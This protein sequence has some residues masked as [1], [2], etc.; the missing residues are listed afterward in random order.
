M[1]IS[2]QAARS[3]TQAALKAATLKDVSVRVT[4]SARGYLRFSQNQA[5]ASG[6]A[7][8]L[9]V[10]VSASVDGRSASVRGSGGDREALARL[11]AQ[12]EELARIAPVDPELMPPL[13]PQTY[14]QVDARDR[15]SAAIGA[16]ARAE[17]AGKMLRV[18][19]KARLDAAGMI[20]S[21][22]VAVA[23]ANT[24]GLFAY[25]A[26][27]EV[28][29]SM[30]CRTRDGTG[31]GWASAASHRIADL[32][33]TALATRAAD[34]ATLSQNPE[35]LTPGRVTVVLEPAAV[36]DLLA[37]LGFALDRRS[38]DEG[39]SAFSRAG[40]GTRIGEAIGQ[41]SITLR[42]N[43]AEPLCPS[44][45]FAGDGQPHPATT[46]IDGGVLKALACSRYWAKR[47][48]LSPLPRPASFL[49]SGGS[50][51]VDE[52]VQ[53]VDR[54]V[55]VTRFWYNRML[56]PQTILATGLTRD[57]TFLIEQGK[58]VR[59][60]KNMRYNESPLTLLKNVLALGRP[61]RVGGGRQTVVVPPMVVADFNFSSLSDAV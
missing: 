20:E 57:G 39:R 6:E 26:S 21:A 53:G 30:T 55:L 50:A 37:F 29:A 23:L 18:A 13:G 47:E 58:V 9:E 25:H 43:P 60:I 19:N 31:S 33:P 51:S 11:V 7:E 49:L 46:W 16:D 17:L 5:A 40:G 24:A 34:K 38:A 1:S 42:S 54:G 12:A 35:E 59:A 27:T 3:L 41:S 4:S 8:R 61:E 28:S 48:G 36:A 52:L 10:E 44:I 45:P 22:D 32:D 2:K 15:A 14:A 56:E